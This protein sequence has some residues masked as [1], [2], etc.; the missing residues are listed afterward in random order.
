MIKFTDIVVDLS[1]GDSG[2]G[3]VV[4][5]L[6]KKRDYDIVMRVNGSSNAG[7]T[8]YH[9]EQK[10]VTH[11]VPT[12]IF[13]GKISIIGSECVLNVKKFLKEV[14]ELKDAG[15]DVDGKILISKECHIV[16]D[17]HIKEEERESKI[18]T[19]KQGVGPCIR[20][21]YARVGI[22]AESIEELKPFVIDLYDFLFHP[23]KQY[24]ILCEGA[25]G[26][27]LDISQGDYPFVTSS[28]TGVS[29]ALLNYIPYSK[30]RN[31]Y[32]VAKAYDTYVGAKSF[33]ANDPVFAK[34]RE[35]GGEFGATTGRPRQCN[36]LNLDNLCKA[37]NINGVTNLIISKMDVL[38]QLNDQFDNKYWNTIYEK[39]VVGYSNEE[40]FKDYVACYVYNECQ[41]FTKHAFNSDDDVNNGIVWRYSPTDGV[42]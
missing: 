31:V 40:D 41:D 1:H 20:D 29:G 19:T 34:L 33:E 32:G 23:K 8:I 17:E 25:Q 4:Y 14:Q 36:W 42:E 7:H 28:H 16:T 15:I 39:D 10:F 13:H 5:E 30:V 3:A 24:G 22:R 6:S 18:G 35:I 2:K 21:K 26:Q 37:I 27:F 12:G 11:I 9:N 38:K